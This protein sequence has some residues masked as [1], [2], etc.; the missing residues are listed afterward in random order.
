MEFFEFV[1]DLEQQTVDTYRELAHLCRTNEGVKNILLMLSADHDKHMQTLEKMKAKTQFEMTKTEAFRAARKLFDEMQRDKK[2]FSCDID[3]MK[4]Y[5]EA[6]D[7]VQ[8]K[9]QFYEEMVGRMDTEEN[10][11]LVKHLAAEEKKQGSVLDNIIE[12]V[13]RPDTWLENAE[14]HHLDEY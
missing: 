14:F 7:L 3:Q 5:K 6:R 1:I 13:S 8:K 2:V 12:M 10:K 11:N 4:L 9:Q